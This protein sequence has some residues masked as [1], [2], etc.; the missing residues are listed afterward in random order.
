[1]RKKKVQG[2][3]GFLWSTHLQ[4]TYFHWHLGLLHITS[5]SPAWPSSCCTSTDDMSCSESAV[6]Q[7]IWCWPST[8]LSFSGELLLKIFVK[9]ANSTALKNM[10]ASYTGRPNLQSVE[11]TYIANLEA[12]TKFSGRSSCIYKQPSLFS[13]VL[14][15]E[16][17]IL[18]RNKKLDGNRTAF[19]RKGLEDWD[20]QKRC[21]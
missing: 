7:I 18:V 13:P 12:W 10:E 20:S 1:M 15:Q 17:F 8:N 5:L 16:D 6:F 11:H 4:L 14:R 19:R 2:K 21:L 3:Y 9:A